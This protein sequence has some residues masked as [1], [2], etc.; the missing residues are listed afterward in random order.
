MDA[1]REEW[2]RSLSLAS[3]SRVA[4]AAAAVAVV[5]DRLRRDPVDHRRRDSEAGSQAGCRGSRGREAC[6]GFAS[7]RG[8]A[9][10]DC[11]ASVVR[12]ERRRRQKGR[13]RRKD[14]GR[15]LR[16]WAEL[17]CRGLASEAR[18]EWRLWRRERRVAAAEAAAHV[19]VDW[20]EAAEQRRWRPVAGR[21]R[22][23][24]EEAPV[25]E[26]RD[27]PRT[28]AVAEDRP[29]EPGPVRSVGSTAAALGPSPAVAEQALAVAVAAAPSVRRLEQDASSSSSVL[30]LCE[31]V[32]GP[33][34][35]ARACTRSRT[36]I[37]RT[38]A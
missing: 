14:R 11:W 37:C 6:T 24:E 3:T 33:G 20:A 17:R 13:C 15:P 8:A 4:V 10:K 22:G 34:P 19:P 38:G 1:R 2:R 29:L 23:A 21:G 27:K 16:W 9:A 7:S 32:L 35:D 12:G 30:K 36:D 28:V 5:A 18:W 31:W 25:L 26:A